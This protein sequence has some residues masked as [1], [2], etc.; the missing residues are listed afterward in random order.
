MCSIIVLLTLIRVSTNINVNSDDTGIFYTD[1]YTHTVATTGQMSLVIFLLYSCIRNATEWRGNTN[2]GTGMFGF[3]AGDAVIRL[4][5]VITPAW[6]Q[7]SVWAHGCAQSPA[8]LIKA[9][10]GA[11]CQ[12]PR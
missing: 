2:S 4:C 1:P 10:V 9:N 12:Q 7:S 11:V 6:A 8:P 3:Q 5:L